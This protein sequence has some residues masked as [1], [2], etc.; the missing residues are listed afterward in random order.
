MTTD[1][2]DHALIVEGDEEVSKLM[3]KMGRLLQQLKGRVKE[4]FGVTVEFD[5]HIDLNHCQGYEEGFKVSWDD[6]DSTTIDIMVT[7]LYRLAGDC[8][9]KVGVRIPFDVFEVVVDMLERC[10]YVAVGPAKVN[11]N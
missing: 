10:R 7:E 8:R 6:E 2:M 1:D 3:N 11:E 4:A 9:S 5:F